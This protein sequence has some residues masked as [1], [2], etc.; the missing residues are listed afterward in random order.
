MGAE[1]A[2]AATCGFC[3]KCCGMC[4]DERPSPLFLTYT[5]LINLPMA[6]YAIWAGAT[7]FSEPCEMWIDPG[8]WLIVAACLSV[9]FILF[10]LRI[11]ITLAR[12]Y[13]EHAQEVA[14]LEEGKGAPA[15]PAKSSCASDYLWGRSY[16]A[17][18]VAR[19]LRQQSAGP[20]GGASWFADGR[21][22]RARPRS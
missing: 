8:P 7:V 11:Y 21:A 15:S 10:A 20:C 19:V 22:A 6:A 3:G 12:P 17:P 1:K 4:P 16:R 2:C 13:E 5:T 18:P 9:F 14:R